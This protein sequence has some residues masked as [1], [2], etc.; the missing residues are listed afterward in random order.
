[1]NK[2]SFMKNVVIL[3]FSQILVKILGMIYKLVI[4]NIPG[5]GDEGLGYY[6]AGYQIYVVL[7]TISSI[8]I[9]NVIS[10]LISERLAKDDKIG[11]QRVFKLS[12]ILFSTI[13][14]V[15]SLGLWFGADFIATNILH[16]QDTAYVMR[17]LAPAIVF[18][19]M[20]SVLRGYFSGQRDVKPTSVTQVL[21]QVFNC[22]L[23]ITFVYA[24]IGKDAHI[25]AAAGNLSTTIAIIITFI[26]LSMYYKKH[27]LDLSDAEESIEKE[28]T[29]KE[30]LKIILALSIPV[31]LSAILSVVGSLVDTITVTNCMQYANQGLGL[32]QAELEAIAMQ[33][34]G[35]LSKVDTLTTFPL[36][37]N[38]AFA[39]ALVPVI[40]SAV[41]KGELVEASKRVSFSLFLSILIILPCSLGFM[42]LSDSILHLLYPSAPDGA[43]VLSISAIAMIFTALNQTINGSLYGLGLAKVPLYAM[44]IGL[45]VKIVANIVLI[46]NPSI[47]IAGAAISSVLFQL[48]VFIVG[49]RAIRKKLKIK[50]SRKKYILKPIVAA[51]MMGMI[52]FISN[53][54]IGLNNSNTIATLVSITLGILSYLSLIIGFRVLSKSDYTM[55]PYGLKIYKILVK[56][57]IYK[58]EIQK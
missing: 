12:F 17:V 30:M 18:V 39:T 16:V 11:A 4:A 8:G 21:E 52:V 54:Y 29:N 34:T 10:K 47:N 56:L 37:I 45:L 7:L 9:P 42:A 2:N 48:I 51:I 32:V 36:A 24:C 40:S 3:M 22:V 44:S 19:A 46:S 15:L 23:S 41:A 55:I 43:L 49:V 6:S 5:F 53:Y 58:E 31:T 38:T 14:L 13:G 26:Y 33:A 27:K 1:M 50:Y 57:K 35:I 28:K 25:M 20:M